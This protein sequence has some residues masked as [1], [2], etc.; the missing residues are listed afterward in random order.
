MDISISGRH[1][2]VTQKVREY[3]T[4]KFSKTERIFHDVNSIEVILK[5]EDR[6]KHCEVI[7]HT[8]KDGNLIVDVARDELF[9]AI[10]VAIDKCERQLRK[11]KE[12][13]TSHRH[14]AVARDTG[15]EAEE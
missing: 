12:K 11:L 15:A 6:K 9:E 3:A 2:E 13:R 4:D 1:V 8:R 5:D 14:K 10:D 7:I